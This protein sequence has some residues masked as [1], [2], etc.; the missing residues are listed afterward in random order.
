MLAAAQGRRRT[1]PVEELLTL[2]FGVRTDQPGRVLRDFQTARSLDGAATMPLSER[3]YITDGV[4]LAGVEGD[5]ELIGG[6]ADAIRSPRYPL[7]LGRRSC[8][9]A[10]PVFA[11]VV[12]EDLE[13]SLRNARWQ[14]SDW[15]QRR[16][17]RRSADVTYRCALSMDASSTSLGHRD[18]V[19]RV[20]DVPRSWDP[21]RREYEWREVTHTTVEVSME[22]VDG[23]RGARS[24]RH[25][26]WEEL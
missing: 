24:T 11:G 15:F 5:D 3:Y 4:F 1:D 10:R 12:H 7:Y 16:Q 26:P 22:R 18:S 9:P 2:R 17:A 20:R 6:L 21:R 23:M 19:E 13:A 25:D 14:A 8:V